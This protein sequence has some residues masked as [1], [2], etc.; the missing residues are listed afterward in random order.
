MTCRDCIY[1]RV[2]PKAKHIENYHLTGECSDFKNKEDFV[3]VIRCKD[4]I[5]YSPDKKSGLFHTPCNRV[6][7]LCICHEDSFCSYGERKES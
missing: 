4:C 6:F 2:C 5:H 3:E 1:N 7:A